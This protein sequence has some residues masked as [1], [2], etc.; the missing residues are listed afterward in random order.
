M[1]L[2]TSLLLTLTSS[3]LPAQE[4]AEV[5]VEVGPWAV[6]G[7]FLQEDPNDLG[8][9]HPPRKQLRKMVGGRDWDPLGNPIERSGG[10]LTWKPAVGANPRGT[11]AFDVGRFDLVALTGEAAAKQAAFLYASITASAE[12][13]RTVYFG[14]DDGYVMWLNGERIAEAAESRSV[15]VYEENVVLQ[16]V[17]GANHLLVQVNQNGGTW[18]LEMQAPRSV[19]QVAINQTID[20]GVEFLLGRQLL[21]GSWEDKQIKYRNGATALAIYTLLS[22][23]VSKQHPA[24]Q[25]GIEYL[26]CE[27]SDMTYSAGCELMALAAMDDPGLLPWIEERAEDLI[28]WQDSN[29]SWAYPEGHWDLSC[30]Q[31]AMLGLRAAASQGV[32]IPQ[33]VWEKAVRGAFLGQQTG[34]KKADP[35]RI[36]FTYYPGHPTGY[37]GSMTSAGVA[38]LAIAREQLGT[39]LKRT[40]LLKVNAAIDAGMEWLAHEFSLAVNPQKPGGD[41]FYYWLYGVERAGALIDT[42]MLGRHDWYAEGASL[43]VEGQSA[44]GGWSTPWGDHDTSTCFALLFLKKATAAAAVTGERKPINKRHQK[45]APAPDKVELH[46]VTGDPIVVWVV[47]PKGATLESASYFGR[48]PG[49]AWLPLGDG[50]DQRFAHQLR[51]DAPGIWELRAEATAAGGKALASDILSVAYETGVRPEDL[52][53]ASD[54]TRNLVPT[55]RPE[56]TVSSQNG[57]HAGDRL[58]DNAY[59]SYWLCAP[60]DASPELTIQLRK[61][62]KV[63]KLLLSQARTRKSEHDAHPHVSQ[64]ELWLDKDKE[65]TVYAV[66]TSPARKTVIE[67]PPRTRIKNLRIRITDVEGGVLGAASVGFTEIELH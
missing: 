43:L 21:D 7:P 20:K 39:R 67:F 60:T 45:T 24:V 38:I 33:K 42:P 53:Y 40:D 41:H 66:H 36:G 3:L 19:N 55:Y 32:E 29:G 12:T 9:E 15:N 22:S 14:S 11:E 63:Q 64:I 47:P 61:K 16:L 52:A 2:R 35:P 48:K 25:R 1:F 18:A 49:G 59:W 17:E 5:K 27:P 8:L 50:S 65:P 31:F 30:A 56:V 44:A 46:A 37:T 23:G 26:R 34:A 10:F 58:V 13:E 51:F 4:K 62:A 28:S 57:G 54:S 6:M